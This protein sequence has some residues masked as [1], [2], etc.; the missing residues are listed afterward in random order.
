MIE[1]GERFDVEYSDGKTASVL[2]LSLRQKRR[3]VALVR[4][5]S[6][7]ERT[8]AGT[9]ETYEAIEN[10]LAIVCGEDVA[11]SLLDSVNELQAMQIIQLALA[12]QMVTD[13]QKK[14][15]A[16]PH[17]LGVASCAK[18]VAADAATAAT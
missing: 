6:E 1:P 3:V 4:K 12:G 2:S 14:D 13:D 18:H 15:S 9:D 11:E 17:S 16:S 10:A 7:M 8:M 5:V